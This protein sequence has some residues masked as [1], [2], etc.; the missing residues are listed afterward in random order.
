MSMQ[1]LTFFRSTSLSVIVFLISL[2][3]ISVFGESPDPV[4]AK[5][6]MVVTAHPLATKVGLQILK[7]GGNA[8]DA[9]VAV[10][11]ALAVTYP[12]AGNIGGGGFMVIHLANQQDIAIDYREMAPFLAHRDMYLDSVGNFLPE[13]SQDGILSAGIP[14]SVAGL[15]YALQ[16]Y[17]TMKLADVIQP[18]INLAELG[19]SLSEYDARSFNAYKESFIKYPS[20]AKIFV[21][22]NSYFA[23]GELFKQPDLA[24]TLIEI[25]KNGVKGFYEGWVA[26]NIVKTSESLGGIINKKDL[27]N[28]KVVEREVIKSKYRDF[29]VI[30]MPP[31]SSGGIALVQMLNI[32]ENVSLEKKDFGSSKYYHLLVEA[33]KRAYAD[34]SVHLGDP[35]FFSVPQKWLISKK[36][37]DILFNQ[38]SDDATPSELISPGDPLIFQESEETT[39]YSVAD[40]FGNLVSVTT[41]INS[42]YGSKVV[43]DGCGFFLNNEMDDF[44]AKPGTPNQFGLLGG[45]ANQIEPYKRMLSSMTPTIV[46][47]NGKPFLVLGSPGGSTIITVVLQVILNCIDFGMDIRTAIDMPRIHHQWF[48]DQIYYEEFGLS[49]DVKENLLAKGHKLG[50]KRKLGLVEGILIDSEKGIFYGASDSRG[51]GTAE[52]Y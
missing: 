50:E 33:M 22:T 40:K 24:K 30:S 7:T 9:A 31:P 35:D 25:K 21:K 20:T 16:K 27:L 44:S 8:V 48:P 3:S 26:E 43:V 10:G 1:K 36:Y 34:R 51:S 47:K 6:G 18:A 13:L 52:G 37:A 41:T 38:I 15:V 49:E 19:F 23:E 29:T 4:K 12:V 42:G 39:H 45:T 14:G 11:F 17:G 2:L 32:I 46:L 28:Y 5:N